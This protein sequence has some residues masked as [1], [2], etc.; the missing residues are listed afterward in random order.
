[1]SYR[2]ESIAVVLPRIN[3]T[4][5]LP[6]FQREFVWTSDQVCT[7]F[8]SLMRRY[9]VSSFLFWQPPPDARDDV[10]AYEFLSAVQESRNR[11]RLTRIPSNRN[12]IFVLDGQQRLTAFLV[13]LQGTYHERK[14]KSGKGART[15]V[16]KRLYL[17]LLHNGMEPDSEGEVYYGFEFFDYAPSLLQRNN[18]WFDVAR[19]LRVVS[20]SD[21]EQLIERQTKAIRDVR[22][23]TTE[24]AVLVG[25]NLRRLYESVW[26]D[27]PISYHTETDPDPERILEIFIRANSGGTKLDKSDLLLSTLTLYWRSENAR[28]EIN[29]FL[30]DLNTKLTRKNDLDKDFVMK[31]CL[32]LLNLPIAYRV[33]SFNKDTCTRIRD[34][35]EDIQNALRRAVDAANAFGIDENNLTSSNALIPIAYYL[36]QNPQF[37]LRGESAR[38]V[39]NA[40][41][42][43]VWLISALLHRILS[44]S[45][46]SMLTRL[47]EV[48]QLHSS[49]AGDFPLAQLDEAVRSA[50]RVSASS[51]DSVEDI[52]SIGYGDDTCFLALSLLYDERNWGTIDY[53]IDHLFARDQFKSR[54]V[55]EDLRELRDD[56]ANLALVIGAE[57]AGKQDTPLDE[58][59]KTRS[60]EYLHRHFIPADPAL[61]HFERFEDFLIERRKL[62][63]ARLETVFSYD[64][65]VVT[66]R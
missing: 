8:D 3:T 57:N 65:I 24:Q 1:M 60:V 37:T 31:S 15:Y 16:A 45:S 51:Q 50:G 36:F 58:W 32:A 13:G 17:D 10:E 43:R 56:F 63:R 40:S 62:L 21:V 30:V 27:E 23:L 44:G 46:D 33:T 52:L 5:L 2:S 41:R 7:L 61:W 34:R 35:W 49:P 22:P 12:V 29:A 64:A 54:N 28:E 47:R 11:A 20:T 6:A 18:Y 66:T 14:A 48:L 9:P 38:E 4:Y 42:A 59:L 19:I 55:R 39:R 26:I 25:Q 53:Q